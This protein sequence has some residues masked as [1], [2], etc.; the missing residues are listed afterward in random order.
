MLPPQ[1]TNITYKIDR[2]HEDATLPTL[3]LRFSDAASALH[4]QQI[5]IQLAAPWAAAGAAA[6]FVVLR[7]RYEKAAREA[8]PVGTLV[9]SYVL[10]SETV[11]HGQWWQCRV[12]EDLLLEMQPQIASDPYSVDLWER[13]MV[14]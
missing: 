8:W 2:T 7:V 10:A 11:E 14:R 5:H 9:Q 13:Y 4:G 12:V 1:V 6:D 3:T